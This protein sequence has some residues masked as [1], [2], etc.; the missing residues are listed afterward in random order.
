MDHFTRKDGELY[1]EGVSVTSIAEQAGTPCF[2]YSAAAL[3]THFDAYEKGFADAKHLV[4]YSVK[5]NSNLAV[6]RV[7][8]NEGSGFDVVSGGELARVL[9]AGGDASKVVFSGVGKQEWEIRDAIEAG[10]LMFNVESPGELDVIDRV[11]RDLGKRAPV[12]LRINPDVDPKT[13]PYISTGLKS[14]K[15][16]ISIER[17]IEDYSRAKG[18]AGLEVVGAD[19]HIGSQLTSTE[20]FIEAVSRMSSLL[21]RLDQAGIDIRYLD[22]GGGLGIVYD[23]EAPPSHDDYARALV[24][25]LQGRDITLV[26]EPGRSI[27]GNA[28][29]FVTRVLY[30]KSNDEKN[31]IVVDGAMNDLVRPAFYQSYHAVEP[32]KDT[33]KQIT[34][35][36]VGPICETGDFLARDRKVGVVDPGDFYALLSA[37]AYGFTMSSNYNT[38]PRAA[39]ILVDGDSWNVVRRRE[40]VEE[41]LEHESIPEGL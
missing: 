29:I 32:V 3:R 7:L 5:A 14:A 36:V 18:M 28:G 10:I 4:C 13:H 11:A 21:D 27:A 24:S 22:M 9:R 1:A 12:A 40:T 30:H 25:A 31:F 20:P 23:D 2:I 6:L 37:G 33:T 35:D 8:A 34:A 19:C 26:I 15:F 16:G 39:E 41:L 17:G 38:R